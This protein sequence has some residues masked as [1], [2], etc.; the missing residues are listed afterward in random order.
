MAGKRISEKLQR[1]ATRQPKQE[2][3]AKEGVR[4]QHQATLQNNYT[5]ADSQ[6][7]TARNTSWQQRLTTVPGKNTL[8]NTG[9]NIREQNR[10]ITTERI[11]TTIKVGEN[12]KEQRQ[13]SIAENNQQRR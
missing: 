4:K 10:R 13:L 9:N 8:E 6:G 11:I 3:I 2:A 7:V 1:T 5:S 12:T